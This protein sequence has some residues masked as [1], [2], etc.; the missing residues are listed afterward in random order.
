VIQ[1]EEVKVVENQKIPHLLFA[2]LS[3]KA[4]QDRKVA[5][6]SPDGMNMW[7][8]LKGYSPSSMTFLQH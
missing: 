5:T 4:V 2:P 3:F 6:S 8:T 7:L 1:V